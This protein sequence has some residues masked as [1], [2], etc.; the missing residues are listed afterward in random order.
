M[1]LMW[2][3]FQSNNRY[4]LPR[5]GF[6]IEFRKIISRLTCSLLFLLLVAPIPSRNYKY[7]A[8][9]LIEPDSIQFLR[10]M[11]GFLKRRRFHDS[12]KSPIIIIYTP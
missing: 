3:V 4:W 8:A 12:L 2:A 10:A 11:N 6:A 7:T 5:A 1:W 9:T